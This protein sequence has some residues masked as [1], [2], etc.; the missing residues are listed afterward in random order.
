MSPRLW[1]TFLMIAWQVRI[2]AD[3][4]PPPQELLPADALAVLTLPEVPAARAAWQ[5]SNPGRLWADP[6]MTEFR[7]RFEGA[8]RQKWLAGFERESGV[9]LGELLG[10]TRGQATLAILP[11]L[12]PEPG[13]DDA[14]SNWLLLL[15][16]R[17]GA[18][19]LTQLLDKARARLATNTPPTAKALQSGEHR[20]TRVTIDL[21]PSSR[22][23]PTNASATAKSGKAAAP[24]EDVDE[25][26]LRWE[27]CFGQVGSAFVAGP[28]WAA[29]TNALPRLSGTN[30]GPGLSGK[31][32]FT[33]L[34]G[35]T[36]KERPAWF[37]L[38]VA[39]VYQ[40]LAP[41]LEGVFGMLS[42]LGA[43]PAKVV[44]ATGL[45]SIKAIGGSIQ[46]SQS[47]STTDLAI[48]VPAAERA[49]LTQVMQILPLE[50]GLPEGIPDGVGSFQR[51]RIDG[52]AGWK[53]LEA[54]LKR[55]SPQL[56]DLARITVESAGQVFDP[57]FNL[58][59]DLVANLG[60]DFITFTLP[61]AGTNLLQLSQSGRVQMVGSANPAR[62]TS[63]WK[64]LEALVHM[65]AG[66][67][68]FSERTGPGGRKVMVASVAGKGGP[69]NAF[70][71][72]QASNHVVIASDAAAMDAYLVAA[73]NR[74]A[75]TIPGLAEAAAGAG[76]TQ[77]GLFGFSQPRL[78]LRPT[79]E[80]LRTSDSLAGVMP[81]GTTSLEAVQTIESWADFK[82]LP[83]FE[84][85]A[86]YWTVQV[87]SGGTDADGF[88]FR[89]FSPKAQ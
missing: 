24:V 78:E 86:R 80:A 83:P 39:S 87:V 1:L 13:S 19:G 31:P 60:N 22:A 62:L 42:L 38:D 76:G 9:D 36:L 63:G 48:E 21:E 81:P 25:E 5:G 20:F 67:L 2:R 44:P 23:N 12:P 43:D 37:Y 8:F 82:R 88:R 45:A 27:I 57:N 7:Q 52:G 56:G 85:V 58:Q 53:A 15:D 32:S 49:G 17:D 71:M 65:Q 40:R 79:W 10:M 33:R 73:T 6:A 75:P 55:I 61:P 41:R 46:S 11:P 47:G 66:A 34:W 59:R 50:A 69:Q 14:G 70:Q 77:R 68:E 51:W 35:S 84:A 3:L 89:W 54:S 30:A 29:I 18:A 64:A 72:I 74:V 28:S 16:T 26:D 4:L